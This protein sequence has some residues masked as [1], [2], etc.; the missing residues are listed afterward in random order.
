VEKHDG[1]EIKSNGDGFMVAFH[2]AVKAVDFALGLCRDPGDPSLV[3]RVGA[4]IGPVIVEDEDVQGAA[5]SYAAR[6]VEVGKNGGVWLSNEVKGHV[7]QEKAARHA[8]LE[9]RKKTGVTLKG[10]PEPQELWTVN[11]SVGTS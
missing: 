11:E 2:A 4:H 10:F 7:D 8:P 6:L 5:V 3:V 9:W 1:Y